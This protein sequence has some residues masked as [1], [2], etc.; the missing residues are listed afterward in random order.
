MSM[1]E[2]FNS[3]QIEKERKFYVVEPL[4]LDDDA[5][6][7]A[8]HIDQY[9]LSLTEEDKKNGWDV[10][11]IRRKIKG[12]KTSWIITYKSK[13][14]MERKELENDITEEQYNELLKTAETKIVKTRYK[15]AIQ[16]FTAEYDVYEDTLNPATGGK[17]YT[18]EIESPIAEK[19]VAPKEWI[20]V[21]H[22]PEF[23]NNKLAVKYSL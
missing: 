9:Y 14:D 20:D 10:K 2:N 4:L 15:F 17:L 3:A 21:T 16:G 22:I 19:F 1:S 6:K 13:G 5:R 12:D 23:K 18:I 8:V 7:N 11:R